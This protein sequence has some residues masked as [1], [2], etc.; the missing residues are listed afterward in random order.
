MNKIIVSYDTLK[1]IISS[2]SLLWQYVEYSDKYIVFAVDQNIIYETVL[3][4]N[5]S[6]VSGDRIKAQSD[7]NDFENNYKSI[8]NSTLEA[9]TADGLIKRAQALFASETA[10]FITGKSEISYASTTP[11]TTVIDIKYDNNIYLYGAMVWVWN[12]NWGDYGTF[13]IIDKDNILGYGNNIVLA[14]Y[15]SSCPFYKDMHINIVNDDYKE[16]FQG[17]YVRFLYYNVGPNDVRIIYYP[18]VNKK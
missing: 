6:K 15:G 14:E 18:I 2:K 8:S 17:L 7:L 3:M 1:N 10:L 4:K 9:R 12:A 11:V 13:Q 16:V 5:L